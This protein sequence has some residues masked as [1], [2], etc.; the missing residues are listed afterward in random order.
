LS[1]DVKNKTFQGASGH[2]IRIEPGNFKAKESLWC[3]LVG[4]NFVVCKGLVVGMC[5]R[6]H[7][8]ENG[9]SMR[10]ARLP[11][12][13]RP[14]K[15]LQFAAV[16]RE[17]YL[18]GGHTSH[19]ASLVTIIVLPDGWI[20]GTSTRNVQGIVDLSTVRFCIGK[21][22]CLI[23]DVSLHTCELNGT[24]MVTLQG[25]LSNRFFAVHSFKPLALLPESCR[26]P[27]E[28]PFVVAGNAPGGY[29]LIIISPCHGF[30]TGGDLYWRDSIWNHDGINL[31]GI[32]Y[33][34]ASDAL[35]HS[36]LN[37][38][39]TD[40]SQ[41]IFVEDFQKFLVRRF[42]SIEVAWEKAFDIDGSGGIN[43][44]EFG[45]GC[46]LAGFVGNATR[47]WAALDED[48]GGDISLEELAKHWGEIEEA[49]N[50]GADSTLPAIA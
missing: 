25:A 43:F 11:A 10:I 9:R 22:I 21:G 3:Y 26:A 5:P 24:R 19:T 38:K 33:E 18:C 28:M 15:P 4:G 6:E 16:S 34:V 50:N 8:P 27:Y 12:D 35:V 7:D 14:D 20:L 39:W 42:G 40:E 36:T 46:K 45:M 32:M 31:S 17:P 41:R 44:T 37:T 30:G 23:D 49:S 1:T 48:G 13:S 47:L 29:H 2:M